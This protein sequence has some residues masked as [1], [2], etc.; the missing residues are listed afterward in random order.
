MMEQ[1]IEAAQSENGIVK[2]R[3]CQAWGFAYTPRR[4]K[5]SVEQWP[6]PG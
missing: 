4:R 1:S 3:R 2:L 6:Q 5:R